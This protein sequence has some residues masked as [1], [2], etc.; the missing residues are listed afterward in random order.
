MVARYGFHSARNESR[1]N[2]NSKKKITEATPVSPEQSDQNTAWYDSLET[3]PEVEHLYGP[4]SIKFSDTIKR[5]D[6][7]D[8]HEQHKINY[9]KAY[10]KYQD[11]KDLSKEEKKELVDKEGSSALG[12]RNGGK[13]QYIDIDP[14]WAVI[15]HTAVDRPA[16][17]DGSRYAKKWLRTGK[18]VH[19]LVSPDGTIHQIQSIHKQ[20]VH[21]G[22]AN[23]EFG[24]DQGIG[25]INSFGIE[26]DAK[27][28]K[29]VTPAQQE[30]VIRLLKL[31]NIKAQNIV[32]HGEIKHPGKEKQ[33]GQT[34]LQ[35]IRGGPDFSYGDDYK[36]NPHGTWMPPIEVT[37]KMGWGNK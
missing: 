32:G 28:D 15:H 1:D 24:K 36:P 2:G 16:D 12:R 22:Q 19:F 33:A 25:N 13:K 11:T 35:K 14:K 17:H 5:V 10:Q 18:G 6:G 30:A 37:P 29:H 21:T 8:D 26:V 3:D 27:N 31:L 34:I 4:R 23:T 9:E 7:W 20:G